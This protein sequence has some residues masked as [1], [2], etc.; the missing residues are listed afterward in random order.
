MNKLF[1]SEV[2]TFSLHFFRRPPESSPENIHIFTFYLR[3]SKAAVHPYE[4]AT[5]RDFISS[6][7]S[8]ANFVHT[9]RH[10]DIDTIGV[11]SKRACVCHAFVCR[12][13]DTT[14]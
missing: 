12:S 13:S 8:L 11:S 9:I 5:S 2:T 1:N 10:L 14:T 4:N 3:I 6:R 7:R